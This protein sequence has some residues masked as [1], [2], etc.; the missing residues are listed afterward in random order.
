VSLRADS[1]GIRNPLL[2][3][4]VLLMVGH[5]TT[6]KI[7][8]LLTPLNRLLL[9]A[10][11]TGSGHPV[12]TVASRLLPNPLVAVGSVNRRSVQQTFY[13]VLWV[14]PH[15]LLPA[16]AVL[17]QILS[18]ST[19][20]TNLNRA[21]DVPRSVE[22]RIAPLSKVHGTL[23]ASR[24]VVQF[25]AARLASSLLIMAHPALHTRL[26]RISFLRH[27]ASQEHYYILVMP[28]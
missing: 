4:N 17:A 14:S 6:N 20:R 15:V 12:T 10:T 3:K 7:A 8:V 9:V 13:F 23:D 26:L 21:V 2:L 5:G 16:R 11:M 19:S 1:P 18:A 25:T 27:F 22:A 24:A 28:P